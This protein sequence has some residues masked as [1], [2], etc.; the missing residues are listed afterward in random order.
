MKCYS[1]NEVFPYVE[2]SAITKI[3]RSKFRTS[4]LPPSTTLSSSINY[5]GHPPPVE[6]KEGGAT[7]DRRII[8]PSGGV[9]ETRTGGELSFPTGEL[10]LGG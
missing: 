9:D 7:L 4:Y 5:N 1:D 3:Q 8:G 10:S 6:L 2:S